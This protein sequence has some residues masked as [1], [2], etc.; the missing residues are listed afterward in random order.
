MKKLLF[1]FQLLFVA[2]LSQ[3]QFV[4]S[5]KVTDVDGNKLAGANVQLEHSPKG[6]VTDLQGC[7]QL[8]VN[9]I[10]NY[11]L[12]ASFLGFTKLQE[13]VEVTKNLELNFTLTA[14]SILADEIIVKSTRADANTPVTFSLLSKKDFVKLNNKHE[15][16]ALA[17]ALYG[18]KKT[19]TLIKKIDD[20]LKQNNKKHLFEEVK[21][22]VL[23]EGTP[24]AKAVKSLS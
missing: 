15:K 24:I 22:R 7:Y 11:T 18:L 20:H 17:A 13:T 19:K 12:T 23:L 3:A 9:K 5:G 4:I 14:K 6:T 10:G 16:D 8:E 21:R 2:L 1:V